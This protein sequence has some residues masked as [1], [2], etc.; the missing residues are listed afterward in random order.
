MN[1]QELS[2]TGS[3]V[4]VLLWC[5]I[6]GTICYSTIPSEP[7]KKFTEKHRPLVEGFNSTFKKKKKQKQNK[8]N[9]KNTV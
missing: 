2:S 1:N 4:F 8:N 7:Y 5:G 9:N 6:N 3:D